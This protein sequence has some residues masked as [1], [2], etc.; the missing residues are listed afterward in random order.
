MR[1]PAPEKTNSELVGQGWN[2]RM[3]RTL[4]VKKTPLLK[5]LPKKERN[6]VPV[7]PKAGTGRVRFQEG[8]GSAQEIHGS[9]NGDRP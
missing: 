5:E 7:Y 6:G 8:G 9:Q 2:K 4:D 3:E 1:P